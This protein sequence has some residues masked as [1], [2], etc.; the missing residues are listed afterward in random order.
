MKTLNLKEDF[1]LN[2]YNTDTLKEYKKFVSFFDFVIGNPPYIRIHNLDEQLR[3][4]L[5]SFAFTDRGNI[6]IYVA[7]FET[8]LEMLKENGVLGFI[9]PNSYFKNTSYSKFRKFLIKNQ[10][11]KTVI[12]FKSEK[13]FENYSTYTAV[14]VL[15]KS[16]SEHIE[17]KEKRGA[18]IKTVNKIKYSQVKEKFDFASENETLF[19]SK[20]ENKSE[21][22]EDYFTVQYGFATLRDK[23]FISDVKEINEKEVLFNGFVLEKAILKKIVK[24]SK[25]KGSNYEYIIFP[26]KT[27][28]KSLRP[29]SEEELKNL[30]PK[31]YEYLLLNKDELLKR[32][33]EKN[34]Q[35]FEFGRSQGLKN[36]MKEKLVLST[37]MKEKL[38]IY[39]LPKDIFVYSGL[40]ITKK[41]DSP[42]ALEYVQ[43]LLMSED[44][45]NY[46]FIRGKDFANGYKGITSKLIKEFPL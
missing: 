35:W 5:K 34:R 1:F 40:F 29:Y 44:F 46:I 17:Y 42:Y 16:K 10:L 45:K 43:K 12:N 33:I 20:L 38:S 6:D 8:G 39:R 21:K 19:L 4:F 7:F 18:K 30:F 22:I 2:F 26:Y 3:D 31:A 41:E 24:G 27:E 36:C 14:T 9:T 11:L 15:Q 37:L 13:I 25:F 23:I 32:D 28:N